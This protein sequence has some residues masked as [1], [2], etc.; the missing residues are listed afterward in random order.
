MSNRISFHHN[1]SKLNRTNFAKEKVAA[2][3]NKAGDKFLRTPDKSTVDILIPVSP[4]YTRILQRK[5]EF[6]NDSSLEK[7]YLSSP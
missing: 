1:C 3:Y 7:N 5:L 4:V 2:E 6:Q